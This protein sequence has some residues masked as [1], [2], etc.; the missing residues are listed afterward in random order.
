MLSLNPYSELF[1]EYDVGA[2][3]HTH[4]IVKIYAI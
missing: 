4:Y 3:L 1:S 2:E